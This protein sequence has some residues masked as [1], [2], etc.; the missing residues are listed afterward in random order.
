MC[1]LDPAFDTQLFMVPTAFI[2][3][4]PELF[5][6][7]TETKTTLCCSCLE[8]METEGAALCGLVADLSPPGYNLR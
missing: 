3:H 5:G 4:P 1:K 7:L 6:R 2:F 8:N